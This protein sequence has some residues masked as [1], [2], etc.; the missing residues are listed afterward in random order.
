MKHSTRSEL[1][2]GLGT[3]RDSVLSEFTGKEQFNTGLDFTRRQGSLLVISDELRGFQ[4]DLFE[5]IVDERVH[6]VHGLL[7]DTGIGMDL[8]QD[9]VDIKRE[10]LVSSSSGG[11]LITRGRSL[12]GFGC[13]STFSGTFLTSHFIMFMKLGLLCI[14]F[15]KI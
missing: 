11:L 14:F 1:G 2:D 6:D 10:S 4:R 7:G 12:D 15:F 3:F 8:L 5:D 9:L 13:L